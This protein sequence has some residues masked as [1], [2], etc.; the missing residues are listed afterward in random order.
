M[1]IKSATAELARGAGKHDYRLLFE[2]VRA[3]LIHRRRSNF[4][5]MH[6]KEVTGVQHV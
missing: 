2:G 5:D 4:Y 6:E 1:I 3:K